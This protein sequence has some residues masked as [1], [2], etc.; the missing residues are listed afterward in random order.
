MVE[1]C[2][3]MND[4]SVAGG[5]LPKMRK[6]EIS[7][8]FGVKNKFNHQSV[9]S[10]LVWFGKRIQRTQRNEHGQDKRVV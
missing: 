1:L 3:Q 8:V 10:V 7:R 5:A 6:S 2:E 4:V 9:A